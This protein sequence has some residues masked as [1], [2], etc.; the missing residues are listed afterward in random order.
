M[1]NDETGDVTWE[2]AGTL[3]SDESAPTKDSEQTDVSQDNG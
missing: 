2:T 3:E 1:S